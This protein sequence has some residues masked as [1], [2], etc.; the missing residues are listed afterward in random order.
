MNANDPRWKVSSDPG[1][2]PLTYKAMLSEFQTGY[3]SAQEEAGGLGY[4]PSLAADGLEQSD[5]IPGA[6][7]V[8][9]L[10]KRVVLTAKGSRGVIVKPERLAGKLSAGLSRVMYNLGKCQ[11]YREYK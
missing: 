8:I 9:E 10:L 4:H 3:R 5:V 2:D 7:E 11:G 1:P 6:E